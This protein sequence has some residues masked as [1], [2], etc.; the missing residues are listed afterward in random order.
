MCCV[1]LYLYS[2]SIM[3]SI[4][5]GLMLIIS[6][7]SQHKVLPYES[8]QN[9]SMGLMLNISSNRKHKVLPYELTQNFTSLGMF[10]S[11]FSFTDRICDNQVQY[12]RHLT[13]DVQSRLKQ[14]DTRQMMCSRPSNTTT[15]AR[16]CAVAPLT[17][18]HQTDDVQSPL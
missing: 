5:V 8:V 1:I 10:C 18:G 13:D 15:P 7:N 17:Q 2:C 4:S 16:C 3:S 11:C 9:F 6:S 12:S 14:K